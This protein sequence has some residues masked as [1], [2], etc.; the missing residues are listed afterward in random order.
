MLSKKQNERLHDGIYGLMDTGLFQTINISENRKYSPTIH[1]HA[2]PD[3]DENEVMIIIADILQE[4]NPNMAFDELQEVGPYKCGHIYSA[5]YW[6][7]NF[8]VNVYF[9]RNAIAE[10]I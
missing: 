4:L 1:A 2:E 3:C 10:A 6:C 8:S 9:I 7:E 5:G